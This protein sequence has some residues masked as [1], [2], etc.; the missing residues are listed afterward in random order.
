MPGRC[1]ISKC[2]SFL[3]RSNAIFAISEACCFPLCL[4]TPVVVFKYM[5]TK[6][7]IIVYFCLIIRG[8]KDC[9]ALKLKNTK[10]VK[11]VL[12]LVLLAI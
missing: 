3:T 5:S 9:F 12:S 11:H 8:I 2:R 6:T 1:G 10:S 7:S 4:G